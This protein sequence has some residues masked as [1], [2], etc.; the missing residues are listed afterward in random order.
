MRTLSVFDLSIS[1]NKSDWL[2]AWMAFP[3]HEPFTH[4][5][6][7]EAF[8]KET[9]KGLCLHYK[10]DNGSILFPIIMRPLAAEQWAAQFVRA[11]DLTTPYGYGGPYVEGRPNPEEFWDAFDAW[12]KET[13][14]VSVFMRRSLFVEKSLVVRGEESV[15]N[16]NV[17]RSLDQ[18]PSAIWMEY[19]HK[20]RKNVK[21]AVSGGLRVEVDLNGSFL[22]DF[23]RIY[24]NTMVRRSADAA[25]HFKEKLFQNISQE[26]VGR[27]A[28]FH[29]FFLGRIVSTELV[30][31]SDDYLYSFL[32]GTLVEGFSV[33]ANDFLKHSIIQWGIE[34]KKKALVLG[35][36]YTDGDGIF[37]YKRS[38]APKGVTAFRVCKRVLD[39]KMY[40]I[41]LRRR[42]DFEYS[43]GNQW[44]ATEGYFPSYR[45]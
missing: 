14:A 25:Y 7:T 2:A 17:V 18:D 44:N 36:G 6:Y 12:A 42:A 21:Q 11:V 27:H 24:L 32:G 16:Q 26:L 28:F 38:F 5:A 23:I 39:E 20:V 34:N 1:T 9:D 29:A 40:A 30:L 4:P 33:R 45:S 10:D 35:G 22:K 8:L 19:E 31:V 43:R 13:E 37:R 15:V 41:L 3:G